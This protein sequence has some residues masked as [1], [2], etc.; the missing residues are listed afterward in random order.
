MARTDLSVKWK[1]LSADKISD[2]VSE[3]HD[4]IALALQEQFSAI[5]NFALS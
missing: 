4:I 5:P 2:Q 1:N 3:W